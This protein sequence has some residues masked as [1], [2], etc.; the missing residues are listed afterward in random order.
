MLSKVFDEYLYESSGT[1]K[2]MDT[3]RGHPSIPLLPLFLTMS[4]CILHCLYIYLTTSV[5]TTTL[6]S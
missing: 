4:I 1:E 3:V 2:Y 6:T 5:P